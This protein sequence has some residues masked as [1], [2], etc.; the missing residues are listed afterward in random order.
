[1]G[2]TVDG[3]PA[4]REEVDGSRE[5]WEYDAEG[6]E[7]L[8][9]DPS[10]A[11]VRHEVGPFDRP[12]A[13]GPTPTER[14]TSSPTTPSNNCQRHSIRRGVPGRSTSTRWARSTAER[15][16]NGSDRTYQYDAALQLTRRS[17]EAGESVAF[18]YDLLGNTVTYLL[19]R[20]YHDVS[21][22]CCRPTRL[23]SG[24]SDAEVEIQ[25]DPLVLVLRE[26]VNG[27]VVSSVYDALGRR[28]ERERQVLSQWSPCP[29]VTDSEDRPTRLRLQGHTLDFE[30]D[31]CGRDVGRRLGPSTVS[32]GF[33]E[34]GRAPGRRGRPTQARRV[35]RRRSA[36]A[37][38]P[39]HPVAVCR[40]WRLRAE[41][42]ADSGSTP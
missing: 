41:N 22:Q 31:A 39:T 33:G 11:M 25:R 5:I 40:R 38:S 4:F 35:R 13:L 21:P 34:P 42:R 23:G 24:N 36:P 17:N 18:T 15:D 19:R 28:T 3:L 16:F 8:H 10:G 6:N 7:L 32:T 9:Q 26:S 27:R 2:W 1:M 37:T 29:W 14:S 30:H 20:Q 12:G